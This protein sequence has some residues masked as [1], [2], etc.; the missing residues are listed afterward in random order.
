M[1][2]VK[3]YDKATNAFLDTQKN[4]NATELPAEEITAL[5]EDRKAKLTLHSA[6]RSILGFN[7]VDV[8]SIP[9]PKTRSGVRGKR[10]VKVPAFVVD[11]VPQPAGT[12]WSSVAEK[13]GLKTRD[14]KTQLK[15]QGYSGS[16]GSVSGAVNGHTIGVAPAAE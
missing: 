9:T 10:T 13:V 12:N 4:A 15:A 2:Q 3:E 16:G 6:L 1:P 14:L 7:G 5:V 8:S 11:S